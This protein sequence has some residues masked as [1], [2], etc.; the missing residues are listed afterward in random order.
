MPVQES[1]TPRLS[2]TK[3]AS[4]EDALL[5][6]SAGSVMEVPCETESVQER[7][8]LLDNAGGFKKKVSKM[9]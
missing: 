6:Q 8:E 9:T 3:K 2:Y 4:K 7:E 1:D 5:S